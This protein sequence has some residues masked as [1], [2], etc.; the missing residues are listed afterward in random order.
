MAA[1]TI[2]GDGVYRV[3]KDMKAGTYKSSDNADCYWQIS[4][5]ANGDNIVQNN[6]VTGQALVTVRDGQFFESR[7]CGDWV[8]QA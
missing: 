7:G 8:L 3:G 5:D 1:N 2:S 4:T 6:I